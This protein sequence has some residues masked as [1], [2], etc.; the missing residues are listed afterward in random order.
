M[1]FSLERINEIFEIRAILAFGHLV[2]EV[3]KLP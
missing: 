2:A 3:A 1:G